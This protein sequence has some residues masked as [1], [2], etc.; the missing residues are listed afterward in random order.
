MPRI[1]C[2]HCAETHELTV[3]LGEKDPICPKTERAIP[4][5]YLQDHRKIPP[6]WLM[7]VGWE[8]VGKT[9]YLIM[10]FLA[11]QRLADLFE[12]AWFRT[13]GSATMRKISEM[14]EQIETTK[15]AP[16]P[17][18]ADARPAPLLL[19][20]VGF[21]GWEPR[22]LVLHDAPGQ[23]FR[24][25]TAAGELAALRKVR[26]VWMLISLPDL[27]KP[28]HQ[29]K[30]ADLFNVYLEALES[31]GIDPIEVKVIVVY[32]KADSTTFPQSIKNYLEDDPFGGVYQDFEDSVRCE[33]RE[34]LSS[35]AYL[36]RMDKISKELEEFTKEKVD[37][38]AA[39]V[40]QVR[41]SGMQLVFCLTS[42]L[43]AQTEGNR[44]IAA[45]ARPHRILDPLLWALELEE[46]ETF[47][48]IAF[49]VDPR[50][51]VQG[52]SSVASVVQ[53]LR[54]AL[55]GIADL[56]SYSLGRDHP[57]A[58]ADEMLLDQKLAGFHRPAL[59]GPL[60]EKIPESRMIV[61]VAKDLPMDAEVLWGPSWRNR[62]LVVWTEGTYNRG[63]EHEIVYRSGTQPEAVLNAVKR[64]VP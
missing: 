58:D 14:Q 47:L 24:D 10:L 30:L 6:L 18:P 45:E 64:L 59:L 23:K 60:L 12:G 39:F 61:L 25:F 28:S 33:V 1:T 63:L 3:V 57:F 56:T 62:G 40:N 26:T 8:E 2:P 13:L 16:E 37:G 20:V 44:Q 31:Q 19:Q 35:G 7:T 4:K 21:P 34:Q 11:L 51:D 41:A 48:D 46:P 5:R 38:G 50:M 15:K 42:A 49:V 53:P 54:E 9:T 27:E 52:V 22:C 32:T 29:G 36:G 43:G 17:T 55:G